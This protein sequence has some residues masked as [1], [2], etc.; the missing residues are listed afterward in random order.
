MG[1]LKVSEHQLSKAIIGS[2]G[3]IAH[4]ADSLSVTRHTVY[5]AIN[6][7]DAWNAVNEAKETMLDSVENVLLDK[8]MSG[9]MTAIIFLLKTQGKHRGYIERQQIE[10]IEN[11]IAIP[12]HIIDAMQVSG[13]SKDDL[14]RALFDSILAQAELLKTDSAKIIDASPK[15]S[16]SDTTSGSGT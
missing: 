12:S 10:H 4:I 9:N 1:D 5:K 15:P 11:A 14:A 16:P 3:V 6:R 7:Y 8:A 13:I 2:R